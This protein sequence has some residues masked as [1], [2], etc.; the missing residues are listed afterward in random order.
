MIP[1]NNPSIATSKK[2]ISSMS[3]GVLNTRLTIFFIL[4]IPHYL[5]CISCNIALGKRVFIAWASPFT[6]CTPVR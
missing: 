6:S 2:L 1:S 5:R 4:S 3:S